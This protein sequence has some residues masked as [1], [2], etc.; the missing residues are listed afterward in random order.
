MI[1][2]FDEVLTT[3]DNLKEDKSNSKGRKKVMLSLLKASMGTISVSIKYREL[4][5]DFAKRGIP[6]DDHTAFLDE[7]MDNDLLETFFGP[8]PLSEMKKSLKVIEQKIK[9]VRKAIN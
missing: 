2:N 9:E 1:N 7:T 3:L 4:K 5:A 8:I 6:D